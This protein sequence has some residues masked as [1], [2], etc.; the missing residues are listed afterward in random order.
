MKS[1]ECLVHAE[2]C[3]AKADRT[4][5]PVDRRVLLATAKIWRSL[6]ARSDPAKKPKEA[7]PVQPP[8]RRNVG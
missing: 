1:A 2:E 7:S 4:S 8:A 6:A 5:D 3:E